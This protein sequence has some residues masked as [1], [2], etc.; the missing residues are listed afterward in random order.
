MMFGH[1]EKKAASLNNT[2]LNETIKS[3]AESSIS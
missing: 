3:R 1:E 2:G